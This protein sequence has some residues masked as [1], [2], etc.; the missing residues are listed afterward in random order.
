MSLLVV[1]RTSSALAR[2]ALPA[3]RPSSRFRSGARVA[4]CALAALAL[5]AAPRAAG[6]QGAEERGADVVPETRRVAGR[7]THP[8][9]D[10]I[11]PAADSWVTIHR[12][13]PDSA[14]PID[15]VRTDA[16]GRYAFR[17]RT[18][19]SERAVYF[20]SVS[21]RGIAYFSQPLQKAV[22]EGD[23]AEI[24]VF[25]TTSARVP[26][27]VRGRHMIVLEPRGGAD[28]R[29]VVEVY[30][31]SNDSTVTG[32]AGAARAGAGV[33]PTWT[34]VVPPDAREFRVGEG[35]VAP[36]AVRLAGGR[37][38]LFAPLAPGLKQVSFSYTLPVGAFPLNVPLER[39]TSVFE[40]LVEG[41]KG[42]ATGAK[43][44]EVNPVVQEGRNFRRFL[45]Q[46]APAAA[47]ASIA[48]PP[49]AT[50]ASQSVYVV[51]VVALAGVAMLTA[52]AFAQR[53]RARAVPAVGQ[54]GP[55]G[56]GGRGDGVAG[57]LAREIAALDAGFA[58]L[59][60]PDDAA[61]AAYQARRA[62]LKRDLSAALAA[63]R[64]PV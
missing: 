1:D 29:E 50:A 7:V 41:A 8:A 28:R 20:V 58:R 22:V 32:I 45:A 44:R 14:G 38:E 12:V 36:D 55:V 6:A 15:S 40:V 63:P 33:T 30:E 62:S 54:V 64:E 51:L 42:A 49:L 37:V 34:T 4:L 25:D 19:G 3:G 9:G 24:T 26:L 13:G 61:R 59:R 60:A 16:A 5:I 39:P 35:D 48:F 57:A 27:T 43:L 23:D 31:L 21:Y 10:S 56:G 11:A 18:W 46:D 17:Y 2:A 53:R 47:V 52:L